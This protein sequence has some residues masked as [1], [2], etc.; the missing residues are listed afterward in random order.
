MAITRTGLLSPINP[1]IIALVQASFTCYRS[2]NGLIS[3][4]DFSVRNIQF[5]SVHKLKFQWMC[6]MI[7]FKFRQTPA[8]KAAQTGIILRAISSF[9]WNG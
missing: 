6:R 2:Q 3:S 1:P 7:R 9:R 5:F 4:P 8:P